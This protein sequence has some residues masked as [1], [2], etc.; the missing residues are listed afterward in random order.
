MTV[1]TGYMK[2]NQRIDCVMPAAGLSSRMGQWKMMLAYRHHTIL[3][4]SIENALKFCQ[5][6]ILITGYR[7]DELR[8]RYSNHPQIKLVENKHYQQGLFSSMQLGV[9]YVESDYFFICHGDMP[10]IDKGIY[11]AMWQHRSELCVFPGNQDCWGHP[12]LIPSSLITQIMSKSPIDS[13][14]PILQT[15]GITFLHKADPAIHFDVDTQ[16]AYKQLLLMY[17]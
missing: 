11:Q 14:R 6:V 5:R 16:E 13:M 7:S 9:S 4:Q 3:D 8:H 15:H 12:A 17:P 10:C 1:T 2:Q